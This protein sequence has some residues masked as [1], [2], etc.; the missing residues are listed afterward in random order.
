MYPK[1]HSGVD[2]RTYSQELMWGVM[3]KHEKGKEGVL[4]L[5]KPCSR[6]SMRNSVELLEPV[7]A[8]VPRVFIGKG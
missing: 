5:A 3:L 2:L 7:N 4:V 8:S 1:I 6:E